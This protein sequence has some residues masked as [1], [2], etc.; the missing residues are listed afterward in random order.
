MRCTDCD[1]EMNRHAEKPLKSA[2]LDSS[3]KSVSLAEEFLIAS[4]H[5][6]PGCG[7]IEMV[8]ESP[9]IKLPPPGM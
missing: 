4:I 8:P 3:Q 6:C 2:P 5:C 7:K 9:G 1:L